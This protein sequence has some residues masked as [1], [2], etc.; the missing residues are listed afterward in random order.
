MNLNASFPWFGAHFAW[1][2]HPQFA[3][4]LPAIFPVL[5]R[6]LQ[7]ISRRFLAQAA[8]AF[9]LN[10]GR[11]SAR[12]SRLLF[13]SR[14]PGASF[15]LSR[16]LWWTPYPAGIGPCSFSQTCCARS[17]QV[18]GSAI[19]MYARRSLFLLYLV[20]ILTVPTGKRLLA[21]IPSI[22]LPCVSLM[23]DILSNYGGGN[24]WN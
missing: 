23:C 13:N 3:G 6:V 20:R 19:L 4:C 7:R 11:C 2:G 14:L 15:N 5:L 9:P 16:S 1:S 18:F 17:T 22:N 8:T 21:G 12:W 24:L 10:S